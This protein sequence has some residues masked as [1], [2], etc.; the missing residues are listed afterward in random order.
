MPW[1]C[2]AVV[3]PC[4]VQAAAADFTE[5]VNEVGKTCPVRM[6]KKEMEKRNIKA[7]HFCWYNDVCMCRMVISY[8]TLYSTALAVCVTLKGRLGSVGH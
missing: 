1:W 3:G 7:E 8:S 4:D 6:M 2:S 5:Q